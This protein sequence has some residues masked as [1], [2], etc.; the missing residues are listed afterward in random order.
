MG[1]LSDKEKNRRKG[2]LY[3]P[4]VEQAP[5]IVQSNDVV[6]PA[7]ETTGRK[8]RKKKSPEGDKE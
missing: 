4:Q 6:R 7:V 8:K 2:S 3:H 5:V 1:R